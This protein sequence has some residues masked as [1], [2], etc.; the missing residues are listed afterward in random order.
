MR[1]KEPAENVS[2]RAL[3]KSKDGCEG[4]EPAGSVSPPESRPPVGQPRFIGGARVDELHRP[5]RGDHTLARVS[6]FLNGFLPNLR[7]PLLGRPCA[8]PP[9]AA[10]FRE[11]RPLPGTALPPTSPV[12][13][14]G[15]GRRPL[16]KRRLLPLLGFLLPPPPGAAAIVGHDSYC[17]CRATDCPKCRSMAWK[18]RRSVWS[19]R[20]T[21][22]PLA[23]AR[24]VRP[25]RWT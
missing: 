21:A 12:P 19:H 14:D 15:A 11:G 2:P 24:P 22:I 9:C 4:S 18:S 25:M 3:V 7:G 17:S 16:L 23:P 10:P 5:P 8:E 13:R 1:R 6:P 20:L